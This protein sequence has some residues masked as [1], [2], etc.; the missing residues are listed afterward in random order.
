MLNKAQDKFI[1]TSVKDVLYCNI[2]NPDNEVD[3]DNYL[4]ISAIENI[5]Y[6][7]TNFYILANKKDEKLGFYLF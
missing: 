3:L 6:D 5:Q 2:K 4:S 7:D 1:V